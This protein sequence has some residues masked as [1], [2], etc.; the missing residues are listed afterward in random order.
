VTEIADEGIE[1]DCFFHF[2]KSAFDCAS[3]SDPIT[4]S[5]LEYRFVQ[6]KRKPPQPLLPAAGAGGG[7]GGTTTATVLDRGARQQQAKDGEEHEE[8]QYLNLIR[9]I[10]DTGVTR[11][12]RTG[13][14]T[15]SIFGAQMRFNLRDG[16]MP[17]LTTKRTFW[18]G[19]AEE[20]V[21]F[22]SGSTNANELAVRVGAQGGWRLESRLWC[23][24]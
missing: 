17:L 22:V 24:W 4:E 13:T 18:R 5:G 9:K 1:T 3:R 19:L 12:D 6:Y 21:W 23:R 16:V 11:G 2:D 20:L 8:M 14:G 7:G 15:I 10:L